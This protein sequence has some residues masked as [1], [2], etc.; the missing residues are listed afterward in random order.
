M[1]TVCLYCA[2]QNLF[3][4][5]CLDFPDY[6]HNYIADLYTKAGFPMV[7]RSDADDFLDVVH[8]RFSQRDAVLLPAKDA[9]SRLQVLIQTQT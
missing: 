5:T 2:V 3:K 8:H 9:V 7:M 6:L 1:Y 4:N